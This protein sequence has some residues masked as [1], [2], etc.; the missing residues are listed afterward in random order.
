MWSS[1]FVEVS[2]HIATQRDHRYAQGYE[3]RF[4][5]EQRPILWEPA[6]EEA[7]FWDDQ[8][9]ADCARHKVADAIEEEEIGRLNGFDEHDPAAGNNH[10]Q[11]DNAEDSDNVEN[12]IARSSQLQ[13]LEHRKEVEHFEG[14]SWEDWKANL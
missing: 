14:Y 6:F 7:K 1:D 5:A 2:K 4:L 3:A 11:G 10:R 13:S 9:D 8:E 12:D